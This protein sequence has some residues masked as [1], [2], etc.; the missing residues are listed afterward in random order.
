MSGHELMEHG[1][2]VACAPLASVFVTL[3][4]VEGA[5]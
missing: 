4:H 2:E 5:G 3:T 1:I